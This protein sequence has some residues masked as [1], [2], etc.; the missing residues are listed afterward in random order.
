M[1]DKLKAVLIDMTERSIAN[2]YGDK[3]FSAKFTNAV[4][5]ANTKLAMLCDEDEFNEFVTFSTLFEIVLAKYTVRQV[6]EYLKSY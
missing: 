6:N 4:R 1:V 3:K 2:G 5:D